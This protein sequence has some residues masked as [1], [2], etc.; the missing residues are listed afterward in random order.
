MEC[1]ERTR[2]RRERIVHGAWLEVG[3]FLYLNLGFLWIGFFRE[4]CRKFIPRHLCRLKR[5]TVD[6]GHIS[7]Y[8]AK[9]FYNKPQVSIK[10]YE[11]RSRC[12]MASDM[13]LFLLAT[14]FH[15][16]TYIT[17]RRA[18]IGIAGRCRFD[19]S[20]ASDLLQLL[21]AGSRVERWHVPY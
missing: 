3:N 17:W 16:A 5:A 13:G 4:K 15:R 8:I 2:K 6:Y 19:I 12:K 7:F 10:V 1:R 21:K 20:L 11:N 9:R 18:I 14:P